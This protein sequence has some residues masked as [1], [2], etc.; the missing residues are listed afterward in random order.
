MFLQTNLKLGIVLDIIGPKLSIHFCWIYWETGYNEVWLR[1]SV[2]P[3]LPSTIHIM[4][5]SS[6]LRMGATEK[7]GVKVENE[8]VKVPHRL[9]KV[10]N[11]PKVF[12][13]SYILTKKSITL[14]IDLVHMLRF[15]ENRK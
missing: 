13:I 4:T 7:I 10:V 1:I 12:S 2:L 9:W 6:M 5:G 14:P 11:Y 15:H 8:V 3:Q